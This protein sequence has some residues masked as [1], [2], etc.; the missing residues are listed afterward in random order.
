MGLFGKAK[1]AKPAVSTETGIQGLNDTIETMEKRQT[2]LNKKIQ[3]QLKQAKEC[4]GKKDQKGAKMALK[5]K[6]MFEAE[7]TKIEGTI[8]TLDS[9]RMQLESMSTNKMAFDAMQKAAQ[10]MKTTT[11]NIDIDD[12]DDIRDDIEEQMEI[13]RTIGDAISAPMGIMAELDDDELDA[14]LEGLEEEALDET[15]LDVAG[16]DALD[17]PSVPTTVPEAE[18]AKSSEDDELAAL[19]AAMAMA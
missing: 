1:K 15:L 4:L 6:K 13:G 3:D 9:Q 16:V 14:E 18:E 11:N 8:M 10:S 7:V 2:F 19:Q 17:L 12:V 5:R